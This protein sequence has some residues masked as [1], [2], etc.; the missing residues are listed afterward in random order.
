MRVFDKSNGIAVDEPDTAGAVGTQK[1]FWGASGK[2]EVALGVF[3]IAL[4]LRL[5]YV[6][7]VSLWRIG[8]GWILSEIKTSRG[9]NEAR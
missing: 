8:E 9:E 3:L 5:L 1:T 7:T 2:T 6:W 4:K